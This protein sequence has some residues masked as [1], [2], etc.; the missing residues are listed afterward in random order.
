[1]AFMFR[2]ATAFNQ[3]LTSWSVANVTVCGLFNG[4]TSGL[5]NGNLPNF[6]NCTP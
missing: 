6:T 4:G 5:S 2:D 1:M 3:N